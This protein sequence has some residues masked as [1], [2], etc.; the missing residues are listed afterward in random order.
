MKRRAKDSLGDRMKKVF[1]SK[2]SW[3]KG[4]S[5]VDYYGSRKGGNRKGGEQ[6][7]R[8]EYLEQKSVLFVEHTRDGELCRRL[9]EVIG[10]MAPLLGFSIKVVERSGRTL[11]SCF[12]QSSLWEGVHCGRPQC[13]TCNQGAEA[14][15]PCTRKPV[16]YENICGEC[17]PGAG[18]KEEIK[19]GGNPE[20]PSIYVGE[21]SR[22]IQ[23]RG[24]EHWSAAT[25][26]N[27][28]REGSHMAKHVEMEHQG[29][30]PNFILRAVQ[31]Y[32]TALARQTGEAVRIRRRGSCIE[33][34][35]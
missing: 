12:P 9:R 25:G 18:G 21:T 3:Y 13:I 32:K 19:G 8:E 29:E 6:P 30:Q 26:S 27:K 4:R 34:Q 2:S 15:A 33:L 1:L 7:K 23:E 11:K 28:A 35:E 31:Y 16:V 24:R 14:V 22:S 17:N 5:K 20:K 10:R